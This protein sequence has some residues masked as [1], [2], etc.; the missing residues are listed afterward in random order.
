M[1]KLSSYQEEVNWE[2]KEKWPFEPTRRS[3]M[4]QTHVAVTWHMHSAAGTALWTHRRESVP[5]WL[6]VRE[7][8]LIFRSFNVVDN[9]CGHTP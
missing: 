2:E 9:R 3:D 7:S 4:W 1:R 6:E 5:P 8:E